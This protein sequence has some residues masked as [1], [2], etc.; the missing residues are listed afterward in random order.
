MLSAW[1]M[2]AKSASVGFRELLAE[3]S[4]LA[5]FQDHSR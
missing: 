5:G 4:S 2:A 3:S 1:E